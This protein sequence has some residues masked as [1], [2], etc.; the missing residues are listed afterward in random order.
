MI[1]GKEINGD[2]CSII[3]EMNFFDE[4]KFTDKDVFYIFA[5]LGIA[6]TLANVGEFVRN[7]KSRRKILK[8]TPELDKKYLEYKKYQREKGEI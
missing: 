8:R 5:N 1:Y 2:D 7:V 4:K 3:I 6:K